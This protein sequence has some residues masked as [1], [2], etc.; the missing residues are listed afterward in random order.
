MV[1]YPNKCHR[2]GICCL[3]I[4]CPISVAINGKQSL[5]SE[6][7]F[8]ENTAICA[9]AVK[10]VPINDGCCIKARAFRHGE[11]FDFASLPKELKINAAQSL[12]R[13]L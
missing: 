8:N 13:G 3:M 1:K 5:C 10:L 4:Q 11:Q 6:L 9:L 12:R 2:C 7:S